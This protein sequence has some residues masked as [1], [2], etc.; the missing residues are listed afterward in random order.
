MI[1]VKYSVPEGRTKYSCSLDASELIYKRSEWLLSALNEM[2]CL[3]SM[4]SRW[5]PDT[6]TGVSAENR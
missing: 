5:G 4:L 3:G 6:S 2:I 1:K